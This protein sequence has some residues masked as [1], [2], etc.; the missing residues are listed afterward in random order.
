MFRVPAVP[1]IRIT[2]LQL[3]DTGLDREIYGSDHFKGCPEW[4]VG[5][6]SVVEMELV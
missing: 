4:A 5:H 1:I 6:I 3:A 2:I